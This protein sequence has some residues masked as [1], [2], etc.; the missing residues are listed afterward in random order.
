MEIYLLERFGSQF[1]RAVLV[2]IRREGGVP[3]PGEYRAGWVRSLMQ[4]L[5]YSME[6][7]GLAPACTFRTRLFVE[8]CSYL[9]N[10]QDINA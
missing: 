2:P 9:G 3:R 6:R 1:V 7:R 5:S 4:Q 10:M 8:Q